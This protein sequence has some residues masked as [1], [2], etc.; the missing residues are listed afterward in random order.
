MKLICSVLCAVLLL[1]A[2]IFAGRRFNGTSDTISAPGVSNAIDLT[3]TTVTM[4]CWFMMTSSPGTNDVSPCSK[5]AA[6]NQGGYLIVYNCNASACNGINGSGKM[7]AA[8]YDTIPVNHW[9]FVLC[10]T[11]I[12]LNQWYVV[13]MMY[14]N[15]NGI[16]I[17]LGTNGSS[18]QCGVNN[19]VGSTGVLVSSAN[20]LIMA[21]PH[22]ACATN[23][24]S[25]CTYFT[26]LVAETAVWNAALT[27]DQINTLVWMCPGSPK[28]FPRPVGYWPLWGAA[29]PEP[30]QSGNVINATVTGTAVDVHPP[31]RR[32]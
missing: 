19:G 25:V 31:C 32:F 27:A 29:S 6:N 26:G 8:I 17:Y 20:N 9:Q 24:W 14:Q 10:N 21:G 5:W 22:G 15:N 13:T 28:F 2:P 4:S 30:D 16:Y 1:A 18:S 7:T 12:N 11:T 23:S 3:G